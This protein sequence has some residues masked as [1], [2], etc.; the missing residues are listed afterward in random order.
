MERRLRCIRYDFIV[1]IFCFAFLKFLPGDRIAINTNQLANG[2]LM[3]FPERH[4]LRKKFMDFLK[5][6]I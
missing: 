6:Q 4:S 3:A 5:I 1:F 2:I